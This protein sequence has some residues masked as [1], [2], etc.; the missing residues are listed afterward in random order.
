MK[1]LFSKTISCLIPVKF[2]ALLVAGVLA[3]PASAATVT[4]DIAMGG[5]NTTFTAPM[6]GGAVGDFSITLGGVT[7]D[8]PDAAMPPLYDPVTNDISAAGSLFGYFSNSLAAPGC[9]AGECVLE[10][11]TA[12]DNVT[13][14]VFAAFNAVAFDGLIASG[15]Y[16]ITVAPVPVP[17]GLVLLLTAL[18]AVFGLRKFGRVSCRS[19]QPALA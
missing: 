2:L 13:P 14:P 7:F 15:A 17:A 18:L 3:L 4:Y 5:Q 8:T 19:R 1:R 6:G 16:I 10:F 11:E 12:V 9:P